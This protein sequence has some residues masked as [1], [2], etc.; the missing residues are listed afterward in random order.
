MLKFTVCPLEMQIFIP[1]LHT[2]GR[3]SFID[4]EMDQYK[5][6]TC[7][8]D[9]VTSFMKLQQL[10]FFFFNLRGSRRSLIILRTMSL[11]VKDLKMWSLSLACALNNYS[12]PQT[13]CVK[14][15]T[16][17]QLLWLF[18]IHQCFHVWCWKCF[19]IHV[20]NFFSKRKMRND[21]SFT[22]DLSVYSLF[23]QRLDFEHEWVPASSWRPAC[24]GMARFWGSAV[25]PLWGTCAT[26]GIE[27][28]RCLRLQPLP[29]TN[30]GSRELW[31]IDSDVP[32]IVRDTHHV[33]IRRFLGKY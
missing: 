2:R 4:K 11:Y 17:T 23:G 10:Y 22:E 18:L 14:L 24:T 9:L 33:L 3:V 1:H 19:G 20:G 5:S 16:D 30:T 29:S 27:I 21:L 15:Y 8:P 28:C 13:C 26:R 25:A 6:C 7:F 31:M 32:C 12:V